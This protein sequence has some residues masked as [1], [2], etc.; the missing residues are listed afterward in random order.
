VARYQEG[1]AE[2]QRVAEYTFGVEARAKADELSQAKFRLDN[3]DHPATQRVY[4]ADPS[5]QMDDMELIGEGLPPDPNDPLADGVAGEGDPNDPFYQPPVGLTGSTNM[6]PAVVA[7]S[8]TNTLPAVVTGVATNTV[9]APAQQADTS[10][11]TEI[12]L[13]QFRAMHDIKAESLLEDPEWVAGWEENNPGMTLT[14][15]TA[16][17]IALGM[18]RKKYFIKTNN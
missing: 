10:G 4:Q 18:L 5:L 1:E 11:F 7:G 3:P 16:R 13:Q 9:A 14:E 17:E 2:R 12:G 6:P 8:R 15:D